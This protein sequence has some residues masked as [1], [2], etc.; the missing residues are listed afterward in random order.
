MFENA[1]AIVVLALAVEVTLI[2]EYTAFPMGTLAEKVMLLGITKRTLAVVFGSGSKL[3]G[4]A[5]AP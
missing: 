2:N 4:S 3:D 1:F 5:I